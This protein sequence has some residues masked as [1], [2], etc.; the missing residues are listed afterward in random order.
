MY[1]NFFVIDQHRIVYRKLYISFAKKPKYL[2]KKKKKC[3][4]FVPFNLKPLQ[5][6]K[7]C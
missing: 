6:S 5:A 7:I 1:L 3:S 4:M 2:K